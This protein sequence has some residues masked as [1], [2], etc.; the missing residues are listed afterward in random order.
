MHLKLQTQLYGKFY[1]GTNS[2]LVA[3][4]GTLAAGV[5]ELGETPPPRQG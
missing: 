5:G 1:S 4:G 3:G 2:A